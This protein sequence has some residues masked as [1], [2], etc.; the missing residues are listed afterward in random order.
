MGEPHR[1]DACVR[2][3]MPCGFKSFAPDY[4]PSGEHN[5]GPVSL[6]CPDYFW[7]IDDNDPSLSCTRK[8]MRHRRKLEGCPTVTRVDE[9]PK[10]GGPSGRGGA[11]LGSGNGFKRGDQGAMLSMPHGFR[12]RP[13]A[14]DPRSGGYAWLTATR[15]S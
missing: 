13:D 9:Y 2:R 12:L 11:S 14:L 1:D 6:R 10:A 3:D 5:L 8:T 7:R 4:D 15:R